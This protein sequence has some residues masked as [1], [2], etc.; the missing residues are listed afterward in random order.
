ML[1]IKCISSFVLSIILVPIMIRV[2]KK[3][4]IVDRPDNK[5][6]VHKA[7]IPYLGGVAIFLSIL[8]F[9][10]NDIGFI[11]PASILT[12]IGLYDDIKSVSPYVRLFAEFVVVSMA[13]YFVGGIIQP[14][15]FFIL[16]LTGIALVNGVNMVDGMDG[17]C[18]GTAIVSLLFFSLISKNYELLIFAFAIFGF[19]LYN[20]PPAK[21]FLGDAGS[22]LL[23]FILFYSFSFLSGR[24]GRGGYF[25]SL[26]ITGFYFTDLA[27]AVIR[28]LLSKNTVFR[29]SKTRIVTNF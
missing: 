12:F 13:I 6:K 10:Y 24:S 17:V 28:R 9:Y 14:F 25:I 4:N 16:V 1:V 11:I 23:G 7:P 8:P 27:Y 15:H 21:I 20:L 3:Y 2:A 5:L 29:N 26:I 18:A 22:Y 19:L